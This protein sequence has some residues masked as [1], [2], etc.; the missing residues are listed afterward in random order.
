MNPRQK[1]N[2]ASSVKRK[3]GGKKKN[4]AGLQVEGG[5]MTSFPPLLE[6]AL[7]L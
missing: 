5:A 7:P 2:S 4:V 6:S 1:S 3:K